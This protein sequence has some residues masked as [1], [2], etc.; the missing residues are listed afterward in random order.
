[1]SSPK[2]KLRY[3]IPKTHSNFLVSTVDISPDG[4]LLAT[5]STDKTIKL[6]NLTNSGILLKSTLKGHNEGISDII[7]SP[8]N[9]YIASC[10]DDLTIRIWDL[11][12]ENTIKL[13]KNHTFHVNVLKFDNR[14]RILISGSSDE[15]I[16][17]WD[18]KRGRSMRTL[19][20]HSDP[21]SSLDLS[22]DD[23]IIVSGSY[24]GLIRLFDTETGGCLKTLIY[25]K[26]GSSF[27]ISNVKFSP[28]SKFIL[29]SSLDG[30]LRLW[31]YMNNKVVKTY[32]NLSNN[33]IAEKYSLG[34]NFIIFN[35]ES[36]INSG[37]EFGNIL[38]WDIQ[39]QELLFSLKASENQSPIMQVKSYNNG[40]F[41]VS[42]SLDGELNVWDYIG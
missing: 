17:V 5:C 13:L 16:R 26:E 24:D 19:S 28:N 21:I 35:G 2:Y 30:V 9:K 31:D 4:K 27:P 42:I 7:F 22:F 29:S 25:D 6:W 38:F 18:C 36:M 15:N 37:D 11:K 3:K 8:N 14:S 34:T 20:A 23:T 40:E 10:S 41:L 39:S 12:F 32:K 33:P 1:M